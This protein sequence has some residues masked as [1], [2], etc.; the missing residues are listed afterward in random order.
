MAIVAG[1]FPGQG[2]QKVGMGL[3]LYEQSSTTRDI[4][5]LAQSTLDI[6]LKD[7]CFKGPAELLTLTAHAQP[8]L[9]TMGFACFKES[10]LI[11]Q[12]V[13]GHSLG[14]YTAL[15]AAQSLEFTDALQLVHARGRYMQEAVAEGEG[16]M[17]AVMGKTE[18]EL[19][20]VITTVEKGIV[21]IANLNCP[22]QIV[23]AGDTTGLAEFTE[24][25]SG[26]KL[27][28]LNVSAPFHCSLMKPASDKLNKD[29]DATTFKTPNITV[30][31]NYTAKQLT[32]AEDAREQLKQQ[33]C[34]SVRWTD[35]VTQMIAE[36]N[37]ATCIEFG[38]GGVLQKLMKKIDS[39]V[40]RHAIFD[41]ASKEKT[42]GALS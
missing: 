30:Y 12:V 39:S 42:L 9:L 5:D 41:T 24:K 25:M 6:P 37:V 29:L 8:A 10:N 15:V 7:L 17:I 32:S 19:N 18:E 2:S 27:I 14:E 28:P 31:A 22:G 36:K 11:P 21:E 23:V 13:A 38:P 4:F 40:A 26:G 33:V 35:S 16:S 20:E 3:E 1:L 34:G